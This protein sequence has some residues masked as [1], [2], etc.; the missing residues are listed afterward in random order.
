[1]STVDKPSDYSDIFLSG[2][3]I[4]QSCE[5]FVQKSNFYVE[6]CRTKINCWFLAIKPKQF[7]N[8]VCPFFT[9]YLTVENFL[10]NLFLSVT[11]LLPIS[12]QNF[13][14]KLLLFI[15]NL[16]SE[17]TC[18]NCYYKPELHHFKCILL[19]SFVMASLNVKPDITS[20]AFSASHSQH[21][22]K[23]NTHIMLCSK[24]SFELGYLILSWFQKLKIS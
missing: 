16:I 12:L 10:V 18:S 20:R 6:F 9:Y 1:M 21:I 15:K 22:T 7:H 3:K 14:Y 17:S 5:H 13:K 24:I 4:G 23:Q 11:L 19:N 2:Y 8:T